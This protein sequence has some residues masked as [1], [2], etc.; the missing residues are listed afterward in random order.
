MSESPIPSARLLRASPP[1]RATAVLLIVMTVSRLSVAQEAPPPDLLQKLLS[2]IEDLERLQGESRDQSTAIDR[3]QARIVELE[4]KLQSLEQG[5]LL[6]EITATDT[7]TA[8]LEDLEQKIRVLDRKRELAEEEAAQRARE[9]P[10]VSI[11]ARG[12]SFSSGDTNYV[13]R[14]RGLLQADSRTYLDDNPLATSNDGFFLR[15]ARPILE[16]RL[17]DRVDFRFTPEFGGSGSPSIVDALV[18]YEFLPDLTLRAGR[19]KPLLGEEHSYADAAGLFNERSLVTGLVP[20]R[21]QGFQLEGRLREGQ[22]AYAAGVY[23]ASGDARVA[24][25][26]GFGGDVEFGGRLAATPFLHHGPT[27]LRGLTLGVGATF[28]QISSNQAALSATTGGSRPGYTTPALQQFFAYDPPVGPVVADGAHWRFSP[29]VSWVYGPFGI[30]GE[31][32][33]SCQGVLNATTLREA[34]LT[35]S[36]WNVTAQWVLT[37]ENATFEA[38]RP[39]R[40]FSLANGGWGAWQLVARMSGL[41]IDD[42]S[43]QGF[44]NPASSA[45]SALS[46]SVGVNWWLSQNLRLLTSFTHTTFDGGSAAL[47]T[48]PVNASAPAAVTHQDENV[49]LT[50][51]QLSF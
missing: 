14:V 37:G 42:Q 15:R 45:T 19:F 17:F 48:D 3:L 12:L 40:P 13:F 29:F 41:D 46:W 10:R 24:S 11:G 22:F 36:A 51:L 43:F 39:E 25:N 2:R 9:A 34:E 49:I 4:G 5:H 18:A 20:N 28:S 7:P 27:A 26:E 47:S 33:Q 23:N 38:I 32:A 30:L 35:H 6:P 16:G 21:T 8:S 31:Y 1:A 50:R 44:A